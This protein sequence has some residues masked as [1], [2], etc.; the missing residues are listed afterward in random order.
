MRE[1][2][3]ILRSLDQARDEAK[4]PDEAVLRQVLSVPRPRGARRRSQVTKR[5]WT[6][7]SAATVATAVALALV[8][9]NMLGVAPQPAYAVTP[10]P[11]SYQA[12]DQS[13]AA[14]LEEIA[15]QVEELPA[16]TTSG[17]T[18]RFVQESWSLSTRI[19]GIQVTSAVIP[20]R[21]TTVKYKDGSEKWTVVTQKPQFQS[22]KQRDTWDKSGSIGEDPEVYS[23]SSG[24]ADMSDARNHEP[25][26][27]PEGMRSW[28]TLGYETAGAGETFDSISERSLDRSFSP[29]Q[30]VA[31]L[32]T[33]KD[34]PGITYRGRTKDR[35]E[36]TGQA[37]S[38]Q[39]TYGGLPTKH[40]LI[41]N[42][43]T[44]EVLAYE[45]ELTGDPGALKVRTPAVILYVTY[46]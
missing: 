30:R 25:P 23:D 17:E 35:S 39:S 36:R 46:L 4:Q 18:E 38:V 45:E 1:I 34:T 21:R 3:E 22:A 19:D 16:D 7:I 15:R 6:L 20:E 29:E 14:V 2:D 32:R 5:K 43:S 28:L 44:G 9:T 42:E 11:L 37:F 10:A 8:V 12:S 31:L 40:T 24:P 26:A 13:P 33:L 27:T 41:F